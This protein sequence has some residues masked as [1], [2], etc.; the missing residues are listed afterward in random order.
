MREACGTGGTGKRR[1][2]GRQ[3]WTGRQR[4]RTG[5]FAIFL[6]GTEFWGVGGRRAGSANFLPQM[7]SLVGD[8]T[9]VGAVSSVMQRGR[10]ARDKEKVTLEEV[11]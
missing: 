5:G 2:V 6:V 9:Y 10:E 7:Q 3:R 4:W 1:D 8:E 11:I